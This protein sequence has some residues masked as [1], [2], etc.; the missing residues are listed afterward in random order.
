MRLLCKHLKSKCF[1]GFKKGLTVA[2]NKQN[3]ILKNIF[4]PLKVIH[5]LCVFLHY[6]HH[7]HSGILHS[8]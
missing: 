8:N 4:C 2:I 7:L 1:M 3:P 6:P 5:R